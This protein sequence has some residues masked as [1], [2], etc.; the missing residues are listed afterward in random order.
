[1]NIKTWFVFMDIPNSFFLIINKSVY[2]YP[3]FNCFSILD[4]N[5]SFKYVKYNYWYPYSFKMIYRNQ[6]VLLI[7]INEYQIIVRIKDIHN[8]FFISI[9]R[10]M[11]IHYS[12]NL[13]ISKMYYRYKN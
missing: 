5:D 8:L 10:F 12:S 3:I 6:N 13:L 4:T 9:N 2:G 7:S 1:M 11:D